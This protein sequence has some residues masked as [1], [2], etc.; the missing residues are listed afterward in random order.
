VFLESSIVSNQGGFSIEIA[1]LSK[2]YGRRRGIDNLS[3][4]VERGS[5]FGFLGPN[6]A[7]KTTTIRLLLGFLRPTG[8]S[9][10]I[11]GQDIGRHGT[12]IRQLVGYLP[13]EVRLFNHLN[14]AATL[15]YL[16]RLRGTKDMT[17][18]ARLARAL[19]LDLS[20]KVRSYSRG[21]RQKL[22]LIQAMMHRPMVLILDEPTNS[23]DPLVQQTV[24]QLLE[25]FAGEGG[26]VFFSS[27]IINEVERV[28]DQVAIVRQG[29]LVANDSIDKL[30]IKSLQRV[31][32]MLKDNQQL[33][34]PLPDDL[35]IL[36]VPGGRDRQTQFT[37]R[38]SVDGLIK[39]LSAVDVEYLTIEPPSLED[40]FLEF[41]QEDLNNVG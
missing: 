6:G 28:C 15:R 33:P 2:Y 35:H 18:A 5:V 17:H 9:A 34:E 20:I 36:E 37:W 40:I 39:Y 10:W 26:T 12:R 32:L 30:R 27:H 29:R 38:G 23:L 25:E 41:Y 19:D 22:G 13:G 8:G 3:L 31:R 11:M 24:Y 14:G 1:A 7:G 4:Q 16:G 21:M